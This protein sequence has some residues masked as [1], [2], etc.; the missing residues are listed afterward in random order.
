M[1]QSVLSSVEG[2]C[3]L[4]MVHDTASD[5]IKIGIS[6]HPTTRLKQIQGHYNVGMC[7]LLRTTWF[8]TR[9]EAAKYERTFHLKYKNCRSASQGGREW[10]NL[11]E[12]QALGFAE[13]MERSSSKRAFRATTINATVKKP[14]HQIQS[15]RLEL[16]WIGGFSGLFLG[17]IISIGAGNPVPAVIGALGMGAWSAFKGVKTTRDISQTYDIDGMMVS[18][19]L[20][21]HELQEM[22]LW[23]ERTQNVEGYCLQGGKLPERLDKSFIKK[24]HGIE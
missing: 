1:T 5:A 13:W 6:R 22:N 17:G 14:A 19:D 16:F 10:F 21:R 8:T 3:A 18:K 23:I 4:Y 11:S 12:S 20:P 2:R 7:R 9:G 24:L 15:E